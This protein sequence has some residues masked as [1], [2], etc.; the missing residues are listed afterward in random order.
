MEKHIAK[1]RMRTAAPQ[2]PQG[3]TS[4]QDDPVPISSSKSPTAPKQAFVRR[5]YLI[6]FDEV[7][8]GDEVVPPPK[9]QPKNDPHCPRILQPVPKTPPRLKKNF[10]IDIWK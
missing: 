4:S 3:I 10:D 1:E 5:G 8:P 9:N 2:P 7:R 6:V